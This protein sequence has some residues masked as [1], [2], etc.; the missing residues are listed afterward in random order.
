MSTL[1]DLLALLP[2][3]NVGAI[4]AA[5]LRTIVTSIWEAGAGVEARVTALELQESGGST[6]SITG[7]WT[8]MP[9]AGATPS[10]KQ[11][12]TSTGDYSTTAWLRF[13]TTDKDNTD[14]TAA[15][16][17]ASRVYMQA[18]TNSG[19]WANFTVDSATNFGGYV[20]LSVTLVSSDGSTGASTWGDAIG[21]FTI[22]AGV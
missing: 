13:S 3:N 1:D 12:S 7:V 18:K 2:D 6:V 16:S 22:P 14:L 8:A 5:D 19:N 15:M 10:N 4:D 9:A 11:T 21:V 20:E 17:A